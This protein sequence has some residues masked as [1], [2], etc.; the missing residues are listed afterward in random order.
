MADAAIGTLDVAIEA[1]DVAIGTADPAIAPAG[2][3]MGTPDAAIGIAATGMPGAAIGML[4]AAMGMP[5][6]VIGMKYIGTIPAEEAE[7]TITPYPL[8]RVSGALS[9]SNNHVFK[10]RIEDK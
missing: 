5:G 6:A 7:E 2:V 4:G 10:T 8:S 3:A 9:L 1:A